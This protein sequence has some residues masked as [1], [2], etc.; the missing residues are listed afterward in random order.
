MRA[1]RL[2]TIGG[3]VQ[4]DSDVPDPI[5][6]PGEVVVEMAYAAVNP[7]DIWVSRGAPGTAGDQLPWTPGVEGTGYVDGAPVLVRGGGIGVIRPG[8]TAERVCVPADAIVALPA[9]A[10][11]A[12]VA[13]IGVAGT[14]A[15]LSLHDR[16]RVTGNDR[17]LVLG[18]SGGVGAMAVRLAKVV[19]AVVWGQTGSEAKVSGIIASGADRAVVAD[20]GAL[21]AAVAELAPTVVLDG[22]GGPYVDAAVAAMAPGGRYVTYGTSADTQVTFDMRQFYRKGLSLLG[23]SGL[24]LGPSG[25]RPALETLMAL[26]ADGQLGVPVGEVLGLGQLAEAHARILDRQVEGKLLIDCRR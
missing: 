24:I 22:L 20:A 19:G 14:T 26:V 3:T 7:L 4:L 15:Y 9:G 25:D 23:Y 1:A 17:V 12:Q 11:L 21:A 18:A 5:A 8:V 6:G 13:G 10:D 2:H 16:A